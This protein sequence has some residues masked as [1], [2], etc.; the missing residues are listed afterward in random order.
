MGGGRPIEGKKIML[1]TDAALV[2]MAQDDRLL[3]KVSVL[4]IDE[5]HERSLNTDLVLGIAKQIRLYRPDNFHI[6]IASATID[7]E[8]F[9]DFFFG[10]APSE[11]R[12]PL[13]VKGRMFDV[14]LPDPVIPNDK[15][16]DVVKKL[17]IP[18]LIS[19]LNEYQDGHC[20]VFLPGS[21]EVDKSIREF[22]RSED[23]TNNWIPLPLYGGLPP[24]EQARIFDFAEDGMNGSARMVVFCTNIAETSLTVPNVKLV[25]D[26]GLA[27]EARFD[28]KR[29][30]TVLEEVYVSKSSADQRKGRAGRTSAGVCVR[31]FN[32]DALPRQNIEPELLRSSLDLVV[33]KLC[34]LGGEF[35]PNRFFFLDRPPDQSLQASLALLRS[36]ECLD[37]QDCVT[38]RGK[39]FDNLPFDPR[40]SNF[41]LTM[42][43]QFSKLEL[44]AQIAAML[45][46]PGSIHF[47]GD[48]NSKK[49]KQE[50]IAASSSDYDSDLLHLHNTFSMWKNS[51]SNIANGQC[52]NCNRKVSFL[53][54]SRCRSSLARNEGLNNKICDIVHKTAE[55]VIRVIV[56]ATNNVAS[57]SEIDDSEAIGRSLVSNFR[58]QIGEMLMPALPS[59][60]VYLLSSQ[61]KGNFSGQ[62]CFCNNLSAGTRFVI[63]MSLTQTPTG[64]LMVSNCHQLRSEWIPADLTNDVKNLALDMVECYSRR[65]INKKYQRMVQ[66]FVDER[67][68]RLKESQEMN[69]ITKKFFPE[70]FAFVL[71]DNIDATLRVHA[72]RVG[73]DH[74]AKI[75]DLVIDDIILKDIEYER[76]V[77]VSDGG[78]VVTVVGGK[79]MK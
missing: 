58:E 44:A 3:S 10:K 43:E 76:N 36:L 1:M 67:V 12:S 64:R 15:Y 34:V 51:G 78:V 24:E 53:G 60:G 35:H 41:V 57:L 5:A 26:T 27:K 38:A 4:I 68:T 23:Y 42:H 50:K 66:S 11:A 40:L 21:G 25:V 49:L 18:T 39:I 2:R 75:I 17:L 47:M 8:P 70:E 6:I 9:L 71:Y 79:K 37:A 29:R 77:I 59:S 19:A 62:S 56:K 72:P 28:V 13:H 73:A 54:C 65:N 33:L 69:N 31:M 48:K 63:A 14:L 74:I 52:Q 32:Y 20:L 55:D 22:Q 45:T 30:M 7:P 46:A 16:D 61:L